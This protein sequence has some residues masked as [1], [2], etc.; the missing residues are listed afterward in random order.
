MCCSKPLKISA[1]QHLKGLSIGLLGGL[2]LSVKDNNDQ[3]LGLLKRHSYLPMLCNRVGPL[4]QIQGCGSGKGFTR[5]SPV[6]PLQ[7]M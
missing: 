7:G 5:V 1:R 2:N 3:R 6:N 4:C